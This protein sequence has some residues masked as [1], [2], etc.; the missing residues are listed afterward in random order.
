[1]SPYKRLIF[2]WD[3]RSAG[4]AN[5]SDDQLIAWRHPRFVLPSNQCCEALQPIG[6]N[7]SALPGAAKSSMQHER[8]TVLPDLFALDLDAGTVAFV[9]LMAAIAIACLV[10]PRARRRPPGQERFIPRSVVRPMER[11]SAI[12]LQTITAI[13]VVTLVLHLVFG[14][15]N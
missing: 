7:F 8:N 9:G 5:A 12:V 10:E 1:V 14:P 4:I 11:H 2:G 3:T 15:T 6:S 13:A